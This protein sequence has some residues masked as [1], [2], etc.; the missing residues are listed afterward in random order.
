MG[1]GATGSVNN[2]KWKA[3]RYAE[4]D[5][6]VRTRRGYLGMV[7]RDALR[8]WVR[9]EVAADERNETTNEPRT[10]GAL[11]NQL[12]GTGVQRLEC[13]PAWPA[14]GFDP[15]L[16]AKCW[17]VVGT[18]FETRGDH[19]PEGATFEGRHDLAV[20]LGESHQGP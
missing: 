4:K 5:S 2:R 15:N 13:R 20:Y 10:A 19:A 17:R 6:G 16:P 9:N 1:K 8:S 7:V 3:G 18:W 14:L 11:G 12:A